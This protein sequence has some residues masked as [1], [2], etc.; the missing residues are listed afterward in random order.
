M[1][2][3]NPCSNFAVGML[4]LPVLSESD[5]A[6]DFSTLADAMATPLFVAADDSNE[7]YSDLGTI[8]R[9]EAAR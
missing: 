4:V 9:T 7:V 3:Q 8:V 5:R 1:K 2:E 6:E